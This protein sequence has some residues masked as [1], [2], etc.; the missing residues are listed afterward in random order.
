MDSASMVQ[1]FSLVKTRASMFKPSTVM[2]MMNTPAQASFCQFSYGLMANLK[3]VT[4]KLAMGLDKSE[5]QNWL[6]NDVNNNGAVSPAIRAIASKIP[7]TTPARAALRV[8]PMMTFHLG[9]PSAYAASRKALGI[10]SSMFSVVRMTT[11]ITIKASANTPAQPE[12]LLN[13]DTTT[14]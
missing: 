11:G 5:V 6:L 8:T 2:V 9:E 4:G 3:I 10:N 13:L 1:I 7:V 14:A 12:K